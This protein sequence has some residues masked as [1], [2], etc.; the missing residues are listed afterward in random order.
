AFGAGIGQRGAGLGALGHHPSL[1][2]A[3]TDMLQM[4]QAHYQEVGLML[5]PSQL[6]CAGLDAVDS[7]GLPQYDLVLMHAVLE[8]L[9]DP[10]PGLAVAAAHVSLVGYLSLAVYN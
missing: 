1:V 8:W 4:A 2:D 5:E 7:L 3:S 6:I 10:Q 9:P